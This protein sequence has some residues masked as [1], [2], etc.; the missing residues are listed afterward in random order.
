MEH[1]E[2]LGRSLGPITM[3]QPK[4]GMADLIRA[5]AM[6]PSRQRRFCTQQLKV[7]PISE[8]LKSLDA[9]CVNAVGVRADESR[10]RSRLP[11]WEWFDAGDCDVWRPLLRWSTADVI[12]M[13]QRH[14]IPPCSLYLRHNVSRV[15][16]W[17]CIFARKSEIRL[18]ADTDP[19][20]IDEIRAL[21]REVGVVAEA[22]YLRDRAVWLVTPDAEPPISEAEKHLRWERKRDRLTRPF[23]APTWFQANTPDDLGL[24]IDEVVEWSRTSYGGRQ[25]EMFAP[26]S[27]DAG[28]VRWGMCDLLP[29]EAA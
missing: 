21:E 17:P 1:L 14:G 26:G 20:R 4:L 11:E 22:R 16:C 27:A 6:F 24:S 13:H 29:P 18:V 7:F 8:H 10:A 15:G 3:L 28:C 25:R 19:A 12:E 9:D 23:Q 5:K 2:E